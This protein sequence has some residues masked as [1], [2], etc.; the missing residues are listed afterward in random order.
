MPINRLL[1]N[2]IQAKKS[3]ASIANLLQS[4]YGFI[5]TDAK[6]SRPDLTEGRKRK[7]GEIPCERYC[8]M[9]V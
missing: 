3:I 9:V 1:R 6:T 8:D 7:A 2:N 5:T 4:L